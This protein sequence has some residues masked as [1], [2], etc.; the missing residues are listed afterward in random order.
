MKKESKIIQPVL[1]LRDIVV[2]PTPKGIVINNERREVTNVPYIAVKAPYSSLTGFHSEVTRKFRPYLEN[3][4]NDWEKTTK[5][6]PNSTID[7]RLDKA[8]VVFLNMI[9]IF[10]SMPYLLRFLKRS[11]FSSIK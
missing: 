2:F 11:N 1:P 7:T 8:R 4:S 3:D 5:I 9:S 6:I 10:F